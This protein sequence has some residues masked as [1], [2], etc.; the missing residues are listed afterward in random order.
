MAVIDENKSFF[1]IAYG[2]DLTS[3]EMDQQFKNTEGLNVSQLAAYLSKWNFVT[4][5]A[6]MLKSKID[7][8]D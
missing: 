5:F 1:E 4:M 2:E 8:E 7:Q 3:F 6:R